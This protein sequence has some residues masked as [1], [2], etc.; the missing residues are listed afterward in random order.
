MLRGSKCSDFLLLCAV[1]HFLLSLGVQAHGNLPSV[2]S[3]RSFSPMLG[4]GERETDKES[5]LKVGY[6]SFIQ[7]QV[8]FLF[9]VELFHY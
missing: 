8:L 7:V 4:Q 5:L 9:S 2:L 1:L 6:H 3:L